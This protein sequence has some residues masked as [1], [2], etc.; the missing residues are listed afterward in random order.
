MWNGGRPEAG[1]FRAILKGKTM[2]DG[3]REPFNA[4]RL[5][6]IMDIRHETTKKKVCEQCYQE[7]DRTATRFQE[8]LLGRLRDHNKQADVLSFLIFPSLRAQR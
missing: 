6:R 8:R 3:N 4:Q 7:L 5:S 2:S 1:H